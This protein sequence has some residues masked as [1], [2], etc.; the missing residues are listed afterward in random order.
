MRRDEQNV[1][2]KPPFSSLTIPAG[3]PVLG[4]FEQAAY[5]PTEC[6]MAPGDSVLMYTDGLIEVNRP[7]NFLFGQERLI[8]AI[9]R[10][11]RQPSRHCWPA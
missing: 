3:G 6:E 2:R 7:G 4:L 1:S 9:R 10:R 11:L 8:E 5:V